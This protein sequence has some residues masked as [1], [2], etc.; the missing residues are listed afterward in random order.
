MSYAVF[1][2]A[3]FQTKLEEC[4]TWLTI[5]YKE[6]YGE[7]P[8]SALSGFIFRSDVHEARLRCR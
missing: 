4:A 5:H 6:E 8:S 7:G 2:G 3:T 1:I